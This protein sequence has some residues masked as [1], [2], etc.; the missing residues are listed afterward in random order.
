MRTEL[1]EALQQLE[2]L[3]ARVPAPL[4]GTVQARLAELRRLLLDQRPPRFALVGRRGSGKS[5]LI[6]AILGAPVAVVGHETATTGAAR[7][8]RHE[9]AL[10]ELEIL[11]TRGLQEGS[12]PIEADP[13]ATAEASI[14]TALRATAPDAVLFVVKATEADAA[15]D[16]DLDALGRIVDAIGAAHGFRPPVV[17]VLTHADTV[18]PKNAPLHRPDAADPDD[19]AEKTARV[20]RLEDHVLAALRARTALAPHVVAAIGVSSYLS[21]R[22]DGTVRDDER[23]RIDTLLGFLLGELPDEARV[24]F[25]RLSQVRAVQ[26]DLARQ[27]VNACAAVAGGIAVTPIPVAD[28]VPLTLLQV[29][30]ITMIGYVAGR[31]LDARG[32]A[33]FVAGLGL[34][35]GA[36]MGFREVARA[37]LKFV[38]VAGTAANAAVAAAGTKALGEAAI[39]YFVDG[40]DWGK[41]RA[42]ARSAGDPRDA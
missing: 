37:L 32:V 8:Q 38:P 33:E 25:A 42:V 1:S 9:G 13:A 23:W 5:S 16:A 2:G 19:L 3:L 22:R 29:Q 7:W 15:I 39:A 17:A 35:A 14:L 36:T 21:W 4:R 40:A 27:I 31:R 26:R 10:G 24:A 6:N 12:R 18:E 30:M 20:R 41:V 11:D 34:Q 28:S